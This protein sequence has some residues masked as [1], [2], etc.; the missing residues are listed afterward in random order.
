MESGR[1]QGVK[2]KIIYVTFYELIA[3]AMSST[4]LKLLSGSP[5]VYAGV[6][7]AAASALALAWNLVYNT[8]FE[9][10]EARQARKGRSFLRRAVH[11]IGF[12]G[13]LVIML[14]PLFAWVL[15]VSLWQALLYNLSMI[16]FFL[17]Y[18]FLFNLAFDRLFGLPLSAQA[19]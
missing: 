7:A 4:L 10:W 15:E 1:V 19:Q 6:A 11:A 16:L 17:A 9:R 3:I 14:V 8:A 13:G 2:R 5:V 18:T 12:E